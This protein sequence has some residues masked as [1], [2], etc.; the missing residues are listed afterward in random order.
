MLRGLHIFSLHLQDGLTLAVVLLA[1]STWSQRLLI[2]CFMFS[3]GDVAIPAPRIESLEI[4]LEV[5][6]YTSKLFNIKKRVDYVGS[7]LEC[8]C[9]LTKE[10]SYTQRVLSNFLANESDGKHHIFPRP[11]SDI[12]DA[13]VSR[14]HGS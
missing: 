3:N 10:V 11:W 6:Y 2:L 5:L 9:T 7:V 13:S 12:N 1:S 14:W 4:D 8:H